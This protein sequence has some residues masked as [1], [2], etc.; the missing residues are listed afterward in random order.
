[1]IRVISKYNRIRNNSSNNP[2]TPPT[3]PT[4]PIT[5]SRHKT[6]G[7]EEHNLNLRIL[8]MGDMG[9]RNSHRFRPRR[10]KMIHFRIFGSRNE[11]V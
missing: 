3:P 9:H 11:A 8:D 5:I 7:V 6:S 10:W 2:T 4:P 1:M